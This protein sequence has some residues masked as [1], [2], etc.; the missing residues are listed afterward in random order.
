M[1][2]QRQF[3]PGRKSNSSK[4][5]NYIASFNALFPNSEPKN[6]VCIPDQY[7][8]ETIGSESPSTRISKNIRISQIVNFNKGGKTQYG[9]FYL[10]QPLNI[11][12]LGRMEGMPCGSGSPPVNRF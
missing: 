11:N 3:T 1:K 7:N 9:N 10:G 8:K 4:I 5:I 6:C 12:Y 2:S